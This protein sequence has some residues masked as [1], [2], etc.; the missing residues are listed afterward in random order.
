MPRVDVVER[1]DPDEH[2]AIGPAP[3]LEPVEVAPDHLVEPALRAARA[4]LAALGLR[5]RRAQRVAEQ[6]AAEVEAAGVDVVER[7]AVLATRRRQLEAGVAA[8]RLEQQEALTAVAEEAASTVEAARVEAEALVDGA[9]ERLRLALAAL[10]GGVPDPP[11][12]VAATEP[13]PEGEPGP[14]AEIPAALPVPTAAPQG[15]PTPQSFV[16]LVIPAASPDGAPIATGVDGGPPVI[17][18]VGAA[19]AVVGAGPG[20][21]PQEPFLRRLMHLDVMLPIAAVVIIFLVLIA[22]VG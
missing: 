15:V 10:G 21:P 12:A 19:D 2:E 20:R 11:P 9:N 3:V 8:R 5:L 1:V 18:V 17:Q 13:A 16:A 4:E 7:E 6:R 22:W 14:R